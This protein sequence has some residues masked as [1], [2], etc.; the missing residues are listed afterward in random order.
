LGYEYYKKISI[1]CTENEKPIILS[2]SYE[3]L[4]EIENIFCDYDKSVHKNVLIEIN[5]S[6]PNIHSRIKGYHKKEIHKLLDFLSTLDLKFIKI[7]LKFPPFFEIEFIK[8]LSAILNNYT[9]ILKFIVVSNTIPNALVLNKENNEPILSKKYGGISG[10]FNKYISLSNVMT[11]S[12]I[13]NKEI[14]IIGCGGIETI[15]DVFEYLKYGA[16]FVQVASGFYDE[17]ANELDISKINELISK[18]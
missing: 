13:L 5:L 8:R 18:C 11:F 7:G 9:H 1:D 12:E 2:V 15:N 16:S 6:C 3:S 10:K 4:E 14:K 17:Q